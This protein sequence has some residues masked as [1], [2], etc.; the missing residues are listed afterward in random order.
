LHGHYLHPPVLKP[1]SPLRRK[2]V[3]PARLVGRVGVNRHVDRRQLAQGDHRSQT[4]RLGSPP[5]RQGAHHWPTFDSGGGT[6]GRGWLQAKPAARA[7]A[8]EVSLF[9]SHAS[10]SAAFSA[11]V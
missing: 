1:G 9:R 3:G 2:N 6:T 5:E 7:S 4:E 8:F 11:A 10:S